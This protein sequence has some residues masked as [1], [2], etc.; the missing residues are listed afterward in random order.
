MSQL[1]LLHLAALQANTFNLAPAKIARLAGTTIITLSPGAH[2]PAVRPATTR[3]RMQ[4]AAA[5]CVEKGT[6][7]L[8][9]LP[10]RATHAVPARHR[11][12]LPGLIQAAL[13]VALASIKQ[14]RQQRLAMPAQ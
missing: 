5:K 11:I 13:H 2:A 1:R 6:R 14:V 8:R 10:A 9:L 7:S 3:I 12:Q 4:A